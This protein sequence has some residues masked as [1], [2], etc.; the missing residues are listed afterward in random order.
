MAASALKV[1]ELALDEEEAKVLGDAVNEVAS[2][3]DITP[4][5]K[6]M[7]WAGLIGVCASVYGPRVMAYKIRTASDKKDRK[8]LKKP[9][10]QK[11]AE[12][13]A[14]EHNPTDAFIEE[15]PVSNL[16]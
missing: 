5:P 12:A 9:M 1:D 2:H 13:K 11:V 7:A 4:D 8:E 15:F 16:S 10:P 3:Y 6:I 14:T